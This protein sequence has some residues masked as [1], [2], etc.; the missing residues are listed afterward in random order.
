MI[1]HVNILFEFLMRHGDDELSKVDASVHIGGVEALVN[2]EFVLQNTQNLLQYLSPFVQAG[3]I[4]QSV[5]DQLLFTVLTESGI[6]TSQDSPELAE[7][8][9]SVLSDVTNNLGTHAN[10]VGLHWMDVVHNR[11]WDD[12]RRI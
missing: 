6:D 9:S 1:P 4:P 7:E 11:Y 3:Q 2:R 8:F 12:I 10:T 5:V